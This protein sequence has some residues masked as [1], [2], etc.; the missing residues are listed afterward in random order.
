VDVK[1]ILSPHVQDGPWDGAIIDYNIRAE[2][3]GW[4]PS[5]PQLKQNPLTI[6]KDAAAAGHG[7][8]GLCRPRAE[9]RHARNVLRGSRPS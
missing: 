6:A 5:A 9:E 2:R 4:L 8:Q 3:M 1:G 7:G